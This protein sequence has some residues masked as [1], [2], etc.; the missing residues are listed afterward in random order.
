MRSKR[1][2]LG[3]PRRGSKSVQQ[4]RGG[5]CSGRIDDAIGHQQR[6]S[7]RGD[8]RASAER[9]TPSQVS[10]YTLSAATPISI[11]PSATQA[12]NST[13]RCPSL[14]S[15]CCYVGNHASNPATTWIQTPTSCSRGGTSRCNR[16][17]FREWNG[18]LGRHFDTGITRPRSR[19]GREHLDERRCDVTAGNNTRSTTTF[20][21]EP[22]TLESPK[23]K[24]DG[25][26]SGL[27]PTS[28]RVAGAGPDITN[29]VTLNLGSVTGGIPGLGC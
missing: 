12:W 24:A 20:C 9:L 3:H 13:S 17:H 16:R 5:D 7:Q 22:T 2:C 4:L 6:S 26:W 19:K 29:R 14:A 10:S 21:P 18:A 27:D 11:V 28:C 25:L 1:F 23:M 15:P 8:R